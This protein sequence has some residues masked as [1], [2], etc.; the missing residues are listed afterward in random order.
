[1]TAPVSHLGAGRY[2]TQLAAVVL[3]ARWLVEALKRTEAL[4]GGVV[5]EIGDRPT[6]P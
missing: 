5:G 1:M 2:H 3:E 4:V 6:E